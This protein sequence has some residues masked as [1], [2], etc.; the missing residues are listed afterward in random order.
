[1]NVTPPCLAAIKQ[2]AS[3]LGSRKALTKLHPP[4][5]DDMADI[6][7]AMSNDISTDISEA[8]T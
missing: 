8:V 4:A 7:I 2:S 6:S 5:L 1:M 3:F